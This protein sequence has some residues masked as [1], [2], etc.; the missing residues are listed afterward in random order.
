MTALDGG[1]DLRPGRI[2]HRHESQEG[3]IRLGLFPLLR[4]PAVSQGSLGQ[5]QHPQ[6]LARVAV[7]GRLDLLALGLVQRTR[8]T[9]CGDRAAARQDRL[10]RSLR[11]HPELSLTLVD[12]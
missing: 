3:E 12:R 1:C 7:H 6:P 9:I 11:V 4:D 10:R 5:R 2:E 8:A